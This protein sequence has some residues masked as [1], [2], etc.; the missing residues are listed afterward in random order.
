MAKTGRISH[1]G[2]LGKDTKQGPGE[3]EAS[4]AEGTIQQHKDSPRTKNHGRKKEE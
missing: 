1:P 2:Q 4:R 3:S